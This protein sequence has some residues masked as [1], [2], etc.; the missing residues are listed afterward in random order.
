MRSEGYGSWCVCVS[1][2]IV[3]LQAT[4]RFMS[5]TSGFRTMR[6]WTLK[7]QFSRNDCMQEIWCENEE[8]KPI[9]AVYT[10]RWTYLLAL[11]QNQKNFNSQI[12][13]KQLPSKVRT[14]F[15]SLWLK[16]SPLAHAHVPAQLRP[17]VSCVTLYIFGVS[18]SEPHTC[19]KAYA[20]TV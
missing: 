14:L 3:A 13:L 2:A 16:S 4:G 9:H 17:C 6:S 5:D 12:S 10:T 15:A 1:M 18:L 20:V 19:R 8:I 7:R 11:R